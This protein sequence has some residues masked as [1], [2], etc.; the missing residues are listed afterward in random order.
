MH[1]IAHLLAVALAAVSLSTHNHPGSREAGYDEFKIAAGTPLSI[2]LKSGLGSDSSRTGDQIVGKLLQPLESGTIELVPSGAPV[3]G[4][5]GHVRLPERESGP[6]RIEFH[7]TVIE[8]PDTKSR[9]RIRTTTV[10]VDGER[11]KTRKRG[12]PA[13]RLTDARVEPGTVVSVTLLEP[14]VVK[15]PRAK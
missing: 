1:T 2:E 12:L 5:I 3:F 11:I 14:F 10:S 9:V 6:G 8:H 15:V 7:F 13:T 4:S